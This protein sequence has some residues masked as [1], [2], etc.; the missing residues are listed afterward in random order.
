M[1]E[2][3]NDFPSHSESD[4]RQPHHHEIRAERLHTS[5]LLFVYLDKCEFQL[6]GSRFEIYGA[7]MVYFVISIRFY[8]CSQSQWD[9]FFL[10]PS[11][12]LRVVSLSIDWITQVK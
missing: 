1:E 9:F 5:I 8:L 10:F 3:E 7:G 11:F 6:N 2:S 12:L 4:E